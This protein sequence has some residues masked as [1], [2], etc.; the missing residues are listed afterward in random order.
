V[1]GFTYYQPAGASPWAGTGQTISSS[2][3]QPAEISGTHSLAVGFA[4]T[5]TNSP[6]VFV[7]TPLC[8]TGTQGVDLSGKTASAWVRVE[9]TAGTFDNGQGHILE[10]W[11]GSSEYALFDFSVNPANGGSWNDTNANSWEHVTVSLDPT[12]YSAVSNVTHIGFRFLFNT[13]FTGTIYVDGM[14]I[15]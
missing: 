6:L 11:N 13:A 1:D 4:S 7:R 3:A 8:A 2:T 10:L 14:T 5:A 12:V 9:R 15:Q